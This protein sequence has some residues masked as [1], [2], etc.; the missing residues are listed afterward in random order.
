MPGIRGAFGARVRELRLARGL[1]Q[2]AFALRA[3]I[4]RTYVG[5]VERGERNVSLDNIYKLA[6]ALDVDLQEL[7]AGVGPSSPPGKSRPPRRAS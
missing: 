1:S 2:E 5:D 3:D 6:Q 4:N 7:F